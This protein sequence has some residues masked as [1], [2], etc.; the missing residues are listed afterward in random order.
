MERPRYFVISPLVISML[1]DLVASDKQRMLCTPLVK[2]LSMTASLSDEN[3][4]MSRWA[5]ES[6]SSMGGGPLWDM[7][8]FPLTYRELVVAVSW[9]E[10]SHLIQPM[11]TLSGEEFPM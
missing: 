9:R 2:A 7:P 4:S 6:V 5:C 11:G 8:L 10:K 3:C 1:A